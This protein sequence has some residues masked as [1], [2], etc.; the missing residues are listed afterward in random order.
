MTSFHSYLLRKIYKKVQKLGDRLAKIEPHIDWNAFT[1]IIQS[2]YTN[3]TPMGGRPNVDLVV[4]MKLLVL[5]SWYGLSD[6][7]LER[8][9]TDRISF[10]RF[11]GFPDV[12]TDAITVWLFRERLDESGRDRAIWEELQRQRA[13]PPRCTTAGWTCRRRVKWCTGTRDTS[14]WRSGGSRRR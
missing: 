3:N 11:L 13:P 6:P 8:Q 14:A 12:I 10:N 9:A 2:I 4:M 1:H 5:Q 7:E